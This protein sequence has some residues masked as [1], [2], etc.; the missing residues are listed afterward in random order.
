M[1]IIKRKNE[2]VKTVDHQIYK[3][4]QKHSPHRKEQD[5]TPPP[6]FVQVCDYISYPRE[7]GQEHEYKIEDTC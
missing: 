5:F 4:E 2:R 3:S 7:H 6:F 1:S